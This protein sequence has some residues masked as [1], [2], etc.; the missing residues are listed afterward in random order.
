MKIPCEK[1]YF[2]LNQNSLLGVILTT[3]EWRLS[4][5]LK[6]Y[7][8][9]Q[10]SEYEIAGQ[11]MTILKWIN[12]NIRSILDESDA[13]LQAKYQL[14]YTLGNQLPLD[15]GAHR[16]EVIQA[17]LK[18]IPFHMK[19]LN[20]TLGPEKVEFDGKYIEKDHI[21]GIN[22]RSDVFT[23][24]RILD[25]SV[26]DVLKSYLIEDFLNGD[27]VI[28]F[29]EMQPS[30]KEGLRHLLNEKNIN[31]EQFDEILKDFSLSERNIIMVL[32][33]LL[34]FEVLKLILMRRWRVNY[35]V[36]KNGIRKMA[37]PFKAKDVAAEMTEFGHPDVALCFTHLS[38]YYS[39]TF[40]EKKKRFSR[41]NY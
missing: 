10:K 19:N 21:F 38:Y 34:R 16:W 1:L 33:G 8:S 32:C 39:G 36:N 27:I 9:I 20:E 30:A 25:A 24:C 37:I 14:I 26:Y 41:R 13:I 12:M 5:Q 28:A 6:A 2:L 29:T 31:K 4:F 11:F 15:G 35:G 17:V 3:P 40:Y 7:E 23:P 22:Y 18:R